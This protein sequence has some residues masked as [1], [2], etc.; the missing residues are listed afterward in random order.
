MEWHPKFIERWAKVYVDKYLE[1]KEDAVQ[2]GIKFF[3]DELVP[4]VAEQAHKELKKR[5]IRLK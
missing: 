2:W 4:L 5:G 1:N 3:P